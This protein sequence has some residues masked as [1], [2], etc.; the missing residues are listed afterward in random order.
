MVLF[1]SP[2]TLSPPNSIP[3]SPTPLPL[4]ATIIIIT[5]NSLPHLDRCLSALLLELDDEDEVIL[6]DNVSTDGSP[7]YIRRRWPQIPL[8]Q[9]RE[10]LGFAAACNLGAR[11]ARNEILV[12]L[13][14]DTQVRPGWLDGL[15]SALDGHPGA[16]VTS[17]LMLLH[18]P[19]FVQACGL[20]VH[21]GGLVFGRGFFTTGD[22]YPPEAAV[23]AVA[24]ASFALRKATWDWLGGF[25]E[26]LWMYYE[27]TDLSW[28]AWRSGLPCLY[29]P[30]SV[31]YHDQ[32]FTISP[33]VIYFMARNRYL[34]LLKNL[35]TFSLLLLSPSLILVEI[36]DWTYTLLGGRISIRGKLHAAVWILK[37]LP[38]VIDM[39]RESLALTPA[40]DYRLLASCTH[41]LSPKL[42]TGGPLVRLAIQLCNLFFFLN[43][44]LVLWLL[45]IL[46]NLLVYYFS[47]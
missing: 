20:D 8:I 1:P 27:E 10:N 23:G 45:S 29:T 12:L 11:L 35:N 37:N 7:Q 24:G 4:S 6:I 31:V 22:G 44:R 16:L 28:R 36:I 43:H 14:P 5:Y 32:S 3:H 17:R 42:V 38:A 30:G 41:R 46:S 19:E 9:N 13:N 40:G 18:Q 34:L 39:R 15:R 25:D 33:Q 21:I 26:R 47:P 2:I